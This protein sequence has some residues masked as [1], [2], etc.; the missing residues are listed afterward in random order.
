MKSSF[1][2]RMLAWFEQHGRKDLPWQQN[3]NP[4]RVWVSEIMLQ[5]TQVATVI[6]YYQRFLQRFPVVL[7][8][9]NAP[10]DEVLHLWSGLGYYARARNLHKAAGVIRDVHQ[11][12]F[13]Q[14]FD[15]VLALPGVGRSTAGAILSLAG[16]QRYPILD[17]NVKRVLA[18][19]RNIEGW[20]GQRKVADQL[21]TAAEALTPQ[22]SVPEYTQAMMDLGATVCTRRN[23]SCRACPVWTD[24][25]AQ[26]LGRQHELPTPKARKILPARETMMVMASSRD[27]EVLMERRP[28]QGV[29]GGLLSF[30]EVQNEAECE[31]WCQQMF[32][33]IPLAIEQWAPLKHTFSHFHLHI[34]PLRVELQ[35][36]GHRSSD[37]LSHRVMEDD[38]WVWYNMTSSRGGLAA[39]VNKL[40]KLLQQER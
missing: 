35:N 19:H 31:Q 14:D 11:G 37:N 6:P 5:Q 12:V 34:T 16:G 27:G 13:P 1:S 21:W 38:R 22:Q 2:D 33:D 30:P 32:G 24:C 20:A 7:E 40:I 29:W 28:P 4:Y 8:L 26:R 9:A 36:S 15:T 10:A 23:P 25:T 17:G 18:R 3:I 39:P